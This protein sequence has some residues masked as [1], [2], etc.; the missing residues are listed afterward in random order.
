MVNIA[1]RWRIVIV[2]P[3][4]TE[5][6]V[7]VQIHPFLSG[8]RELLCYIAREPRRTRTLSSLPLIKAEHFRQNRKGR[9]RALLH[10][11]HPIR[12]QDKLRRISKSCMLFHAVL[13]PPLVLIRHAVNYVGCKISL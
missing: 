13:T 10:R 6:R 9:L 7:A 11:R 4:D 3:N 1:G 8:R 12:A 2:Q 5:A